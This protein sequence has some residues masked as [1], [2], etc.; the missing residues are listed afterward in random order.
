MFGIIQIVLVIVLIAAIIVYFGKIRHAKKSLIAG[1]ILCAV[2]SAGISDS[3]VDIIPL[4]TD[5]VIVTA[6]GEKNEA[7]SSNEAYIVNLIVGGE[8]YELTNPS[9]GKWFWKGDFYM[10]RNEND[11]RQP[12]GTT[13]SITIGIPYGRGRSIQF[14]LSQW[15][16]IVE[17]SYGGDTKSYDLFKADDA[18]ERVLYAPI[19]DTG[20]LALYG[21][22]L[23]RCG[24][25][26]LIIVLLMA[27]PVY[28]SL[29]F[30]YETIK[31]FWGKHWDKLVYIAI[32]FGC[33]VFMFEAG[34]EG[35]FWLDE[36]W[37]LGWIYGYPTKSD[38]MFYRAIY[39]TWFFLMP[40]GQ[41]YLLIISELLVAFSIFICGLI[42]STYKSKRLGILMS[43]LCASS[44]T[45]MAQCGG[46]F[47]PYALLLFSVTL[48]IYLFLKKQKQ[49][50]NEKIS[51]IILYSIALMIAMDVHDFALATAGSMMIFDFILII[52]KKSKIKCLVE[53]ILPG[54]YGIYWLFTRFIVDIQNANN[55]TIA[56]SPTV[57][58]VINTVKWLCGDVSEY[59]P[60]CLLVLGIFAALYMFI[61]NII[62]KKFDIKMDY[63]MLV[64]LAVPT[65][66][67]AFNILYST[68]FNK[69][70]SLWVSRYMLP[71][72]PYFIFFMAFGIDVIIEILSKLG[73]LFL[74]KKADSKIFKLFSPIC[75]LTVVIILCTFNWQKLPY[76][77]NIVN[78][79]K[80]A[81]EYIMSDNKA[82]C[83]TTICYVSGNPSVNVGFEY[84]LTHKGKRDSINH[85]SNLRE[86]T[87]EEF[88]KYDTVFCVSYRCKANGAWELKK[89]GFIQVY[90]NEVHSLNVSKWVRGG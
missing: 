71:T 19:P 89:N 86:F 46:E 48:V 5:K 70:N 85:V 18:D 81:A 58:D 25:F 64:L 63:A 65:I 6:T 13:R 30:E 52:T 7:A 37:N 38:N 21:I 11:P 24:L 32:A 1:L 83:Q 69:D 40:Y 59:I 27:Y 90:N 54:I 16:G 49:L 28:A 60:F 9:E 22:K 20:F 10:W 79:Y 33:F 34:K 2:V 29:K 15:N 50:G 82:Y 35:S 51:T 53:F 67:F 31:N 12:E 8:E 56:A 17:V 73:C 80:G 3:V 72:V 41:E 26:L 45:I 74:N 57:N 39:D 68:V 88:A 84:Y 44:L 4:P 61:R 23:L 42:G 76:E 75:T 62:K 77:A 87:S 36:V 47:R 66:L 55:Y 78:D 43:A 14:G